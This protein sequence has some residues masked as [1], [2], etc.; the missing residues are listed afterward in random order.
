M[1]SPE[2]N[3]RYKPRFIRSLYA[4]TKKLA[5]PLWSIVIERALKY[6]LTSMESLLKVSALAL[7]NS[8]TASADWPCDVLFGKDYENR[9]AYREGCFSQENPL[10]HYEE[11]LNEK[12]EDK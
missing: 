11:P 1:K 6:R 3:I 10:G 9:P 7:T 8:G 4:L 12:K 2:S 5:P